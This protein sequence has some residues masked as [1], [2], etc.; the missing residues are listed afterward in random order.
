MTS[1]F[2]RIIRLPAYVNDVRTEVDA[3]GYIHHAFEY[4]GWT[5]KERI[6]P[7]V[8]AIPGEVYVTK[9]FGQ[10]YTIGVWHLQRLICAANASK[11]P[12]ATESAA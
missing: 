2:G 8:P 9:P 7:L 1:H 10:D 4:D 12:E 3:V 11:A 5:N 6:T